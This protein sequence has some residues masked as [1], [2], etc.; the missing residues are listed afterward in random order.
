MTLTMST[1][2]LF[3]LTCIYIYMYV[4]MYVYIIVTCH[5]KVSVCHASQCLPYTYMADTAALEL[6]A[7][8][9]QIKEIQQT[10]SPYRSSLSNVS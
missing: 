5:N 9:T 3:S 6:E 10:V 7:G 1:F 8:Q 4:C 2:L